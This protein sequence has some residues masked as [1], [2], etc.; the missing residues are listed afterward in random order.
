MTRLTA[1]QPISL[2]EPSRCR[3]FWSH[4]WLIQYHRLFALVMVT[5]LL[6]LWHGID[7]G[8]WRAPGLA[9][10]LIGAMVL[11]NFAVAVLIRQQYVVNALF[12]L[13]TRAPT[14]WPPTTSS[15]STPAARGPPRPCGAAGTPSSTRT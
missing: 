9:L 3:R 10:Q 2:P 1:P 15:R 13:A 4:P 14:S 8:W 6:V 7:S 12:W 11:G 5:N